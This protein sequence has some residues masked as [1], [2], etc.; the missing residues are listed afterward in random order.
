MAT[1][2]HRQILSIELP[3][4]DVA[5]QPENN[6]EAEEYHEALR[7]FTKADRAEMFRMG[8]TQELRRNYR[9][10]SALAF[11]VMIQATWEVLLM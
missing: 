6:E 5:F 8:K 1:H 3:A 4:K 9:P 10:L 11:T 2:G 7:G